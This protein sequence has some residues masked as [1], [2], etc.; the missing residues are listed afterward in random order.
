[1]D[2]YQTKYLFPIDAL[3]LGLC[4]IARDHYVNVKE[5]MS[6]SLWPRGSTQFLLY[7]EE[8]R[9]VC[10]THVVQIN[11]T[12]KKYKQNPILSKVEFW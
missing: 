1:M 5:K 7:E 12:E 2:A 8:K 10:E 4:K 9:E 3:I 6:V 11:L